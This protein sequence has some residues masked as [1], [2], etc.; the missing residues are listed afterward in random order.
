[1]HWLGITRCRSATWLL[2]LGAFVASGTGRAH[3]DHGFNKG[4]WPFRPLERPQPPSVDRW[5]RSATKREQPFPSSANPID[6]FILAELEKRE[7]AL[8]VPAEKTA[9]LR[10]VTFDLIGLPPTP[11]EIEAFVSDDSPLAYERVVDRLLVSPHF[12][13]RWARH[14]LDLVRF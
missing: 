4:N 5:S 14:W 8:N 6:L 2:I 9:L 13:E 1:M 11:E 3:A 7:L 12:G 10:R